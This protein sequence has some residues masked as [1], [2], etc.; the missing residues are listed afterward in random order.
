MHIP[1][2]PMALALRRKAE[3]TKFV[4]VLKVAPVWYAKLTSSNNVK[5][6]THYFIHPLDFYYHHYALSVGSNVG[7]S[8]A[9]TAPPPNN[10]AL[11]RGQ[12]FLFTN[13]S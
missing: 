11:H 12:E 1:I 3:H 4:S 10:L 9:T 8:V 2:G 13:H 5:T 7:F 6:H